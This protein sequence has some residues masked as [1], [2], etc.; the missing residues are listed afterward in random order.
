MIEN[1]DSLKHLLKDKIPGK[2]YHL[3]IYVLRI[4]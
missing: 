2:D 3:K 1:I 4:S